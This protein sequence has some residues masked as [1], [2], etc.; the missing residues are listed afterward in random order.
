MNKVYGSFDDFNKSSSF[1]TMNALDTSN[2]N[3]AKAKTS[4]TII[5]SWKTHQKLD[6]QLLS[7]KGNL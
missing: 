2:I 4:Q 5:N 7:P 6:L 1:H 3:F